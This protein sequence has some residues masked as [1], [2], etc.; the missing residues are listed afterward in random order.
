[1]VSSARFVSMI[2]YISTILA[3]QVHPVKRTVVSTANCIDGYSW[4]NNGQGDSPCHT[5]A[6]VEAACAGNNYDQPALISGNSYSL[7]NSSNSNQ[8]YCSWSSYNL[9]MA[10]TLCQNTSNFV[11]W[12]WPQWAGGCSNSSWTQEYFPS[13]LVLAGDASIPY[14]AITNP[15]KW[16]YATFN[17][18]E[19]NATY[20]QNSSNITPSISSSSSSSPSPSSSSSSPNSNSPDVGAI[21]GGT[22]GGIAALLFL[23]IVAYLLYRRHVYRKGVHASVINQQGM[24]FMPLSGTHNRIPSDTSNLAPSMSG[25]LGLFGQSVSPSQQYETAYS[26]QPQTTYPSM[27]GSFSPLPQTD[28]SLYTTHTSNGQ[29]S[30]AIPMV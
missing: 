7:P 4:M 28:T 25:P 29:R 13:G 8:C 26:P 27:H 23:I 24:A 11:V 3:I 18:L 20:Q 16:T 19:A 2:P 14:W 15:T 22:I 1:M 12:E 30:D 10:C 21:V 17:I 5:V 9:M 6:Y